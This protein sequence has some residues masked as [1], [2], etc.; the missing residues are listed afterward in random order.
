MEIDDA[1]EDWQP[2]LHMTIAPGST[3]ITRMSWNGSN[4][5]ALCG[6]ERTVYI[7]DF[8]DSLNV[9]FPIQGK[10][11]SELRFAKEDLLVV[12]TLS[13]EISAFKLNRTFRRG[14]TPV[15]FNRHLHAHHSPVFALDVDPRGAHFISAGAD[16]VIKMW[17]ICG[18]KLLGQFRKHTNAVRQLAYSWEGSQFLSAADDREIIE[19]DAR[20]QNPIAS[21]TNTGGGASAISY[22]PGGHVVVGHRDNSL[23]VYDARTKKS[24]CCYQLYENPI[25]DLSVHSSGQFAATCSETDQCSTVIDLVNGITLTTFTMKIPLKSA[26][27][28]T[29]CQ[30]P[31]NEFDTS[32]YLCLPGRNRKL[33][34]FNTCLTKLLDNEDRKSGARLSEDSKE[35]EI[36]YSKQLAET[37]ENANRKDTP[38]EGQTGSQKKSKRRMTMARKSIMPK[39]ISVDVIQ[40]EVPDDEKPQLLS[41]GSSTTKLIALMA[42]MSDRL[43]ELEKQMK[44]KIQNMET[45]LIRLEQNPIHP[46]QKK[47][48][49]Q[50]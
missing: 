14:I 46:S 48:S 6:R 40:E 16:K 44:C 38:D 9:N 39:S 47:N 23:R 21:L 7:H 50:R 15:M 31:S 2:Y 36:D 32:D 18:Q 19:W 41:A 33:N 45:R 10:D 3:G 25:R 17:N 4:R 35:N 34:I 49:E 12:A 11:I 37:I 1:T 29:P 24:I 5:L 27:F 28:L 22:L 30:P 8:D 20:S 43:D 26:T 13:G 42:N